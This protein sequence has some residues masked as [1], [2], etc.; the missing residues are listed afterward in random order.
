MR[1]VTSVVVL[2]LLTS[3]A[4]GQGLFPARLAGEI[5]GH[6]IEAVWESPT[7]LAL[8]VNG[9]HIP[10]SLTESGDIVLFSSEDP[11]LSGWYS[12]AGTTGT[13]ALD[14]T[15]EPARA[16]L[17]I[18]AERASG[19]YPVEVASTRVCTCYG[20]GPVTYTCKPDDCENNDKDCGPSRVCYWQETSGPAPPTCATLDPLTGLILP[21]VSLSFAQASR[22]V[23]RGARRSSDK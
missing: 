3:P 1:A 8:T 6:P 23:R 7:E 18:G 11:P 22:R 13:L 4:L 21:A 12:F 10:L 15:E 9:T 2:V 5:S 16:E 14:F 17:S 20:S 19:F